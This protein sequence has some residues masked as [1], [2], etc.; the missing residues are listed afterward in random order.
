MYPGLGLGLGSDELGM[1]DAFGDNARRSFLDDASV[2]SDG[3]EFDTWRYEMY[4]VGGLT[5]SL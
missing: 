5:G 1:G 4:G 3:C 2:D